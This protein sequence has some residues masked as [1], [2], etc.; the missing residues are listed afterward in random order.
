M[1]VMHVVRNRVVQAIVLAY[2]SGLAMPE[3]FAPPWLGKRSATAAAKQTD[4]GT[5][6]APV[7]GDGSAR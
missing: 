5:P 7:A 1:T 3:T 4:P 6:D 2:K